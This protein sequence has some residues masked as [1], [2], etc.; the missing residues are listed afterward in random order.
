MLIMVMMLMLMVMVR[1]GLLAGPGSL[2]L[3]LWHLI[4]MEMVV[5]VVKVVMVVVVVVKVEQKK[6]DT[7]NPGLAHRTFHMRENILPLSD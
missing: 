7:L 3:A 2:N 5:K 6:S 1:L 4:M